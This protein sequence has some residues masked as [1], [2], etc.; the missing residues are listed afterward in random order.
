MILPQGPLRGILLK[1]TSVV[2][3]VAMSSTIKIVADRIPPG[4]VVFFRS[5]F[6]APVIL[7]WLLWQGGGPG[8]LR[9]GLVTANPLGHFW[10]ALAGTASM[11][12]TFAGL[13]MLPLPEATAIGYAAPMLTVVFAAMF[14][15]ERVRSFRIFAVSL[16]MA[17]VVIVMSPHLTA[18]RGQEAGA[19]GQVAPVATL[20]AIVM[21]TGA[22]FAA[23]AQVTVRRLVAEEKTTAI[24][25]WFSTNAALL[26]L[27]TLPFGWSIP[28]MPTFAILVVIGL[29]GGLGQVFLTSSYRHADASVV[30]PFDYA[31][32]VLAVAVGYMVFDEVPTRMVIL[33]AALIMV[34]GGLII[35]RE[36][37][38]GHER[39]D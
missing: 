16:G 24:V 3:F 28:D 39:A 10:R 36:H 4:E 9:R 26:S 27:L 1:L 35:W 7:V 15:G 19:V 25:F 12:F 32:M 13:G 38:L 5:A 6:A 8:G 34:A 30:A 33:G 22:V 23:L 18:F 21:L 2:I 17:G 11:G 14:L 37:K 29:L 31:S 20:G